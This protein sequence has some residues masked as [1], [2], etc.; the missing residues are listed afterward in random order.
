MQRKR[1]KRSRIRGRRTCGYGARKKHRGK[2]SKGGKGL[3]GTGKK[4][5]HKRTYLLRY[6]IKALG[7]RG[8]KSEKQKKGKE[9]VINLR[10]INENV[11]KWLASG[12]A[13][14]T[15]E[16]IEIELKGFKVLSQG[17]LDRPL[18]IKASKF[19]SKAREKIERVGGK[20]LLAQK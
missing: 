3:A 10:E 12:K 16:G 9:K 20:A 1:S 14:E 13:K 5:G 2:G 6:G 4:A 18:I 7:K 11:E 15:E 17:S 19:S 8:F